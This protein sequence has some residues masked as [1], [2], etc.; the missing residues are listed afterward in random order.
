ME[1]VFKWRNSSIAFESFGDGPV[2][3]VAFHGY[4]QDKTAFRPLKP[5]FEKHY[6]VYAIDL[7]YHGNTVWNEKQELDHN[8]LHDLI[9]GFLK[10]NGI[11][12]KAGLL[13]YSIGGNY[14]LGLLEKCPELISEVWLMAADG[15]RP[16]P[17]FYFLTKTL[18]GKLLFKGFVTFPQPVFVILRLAKWA[19]IVPERVTRFF[20]FNIDS[21]QKRQQLYRRWKSVSRIRGNLSSIKRTI[22][23]HKIP[24]RMIFGL[25][26]GVISYRFAEK[27]ALDLDNVQL[28][29][30][31]QGH[32]LLESSVLPAI[33][34]IIS[35][36]E[37]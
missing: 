26:D 28:E 19:G 32:Q 35:R 18:V 22:N 11:E 30:I 4:G 9:L 16:K 5:A 34:A 29:L 12:G 36:N 20:R 7:P 10:E 14:V 33:H 8:D 3:L 6:T 31:D 24:V 23:Q 21:K 13:G 27:F 37:V 2:T 17:G 15:L 1:K 25:N